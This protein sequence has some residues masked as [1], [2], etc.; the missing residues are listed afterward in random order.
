MKLLIKEQHESYKNGKNLVYN[1][2]EEIDKV[3]CENE[4][5]IEKCETCRIKYEYCNCFLEY[6]DFKDDL[7]EYKCLRC[8][9]NY[10]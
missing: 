2:S 5:G 3:K 6:M 7:I 8:T 9:R 4:Y 10:Q 1:L